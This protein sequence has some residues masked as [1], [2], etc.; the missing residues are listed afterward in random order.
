MTKS[1]A[2]KKDILTFDEIN[3][4]GGAYC[5]NDQ[6]KRAFIFCLNTG[7]RYCDVVKLTWSNINIKEARVSYVQAKTRHSSK[8]A[9]HV[10]DLNSNALQMIGKKG[11]PD[12]RVFNLPSY[13]ACLKNLKSWAKNA[14]VEKHLTWHVARHT[15]AVNLL[16]QKTDVKT[17]AGI[18]GHSGLNHINTYLRVVDELKKQAV[19]RLP[20]IKI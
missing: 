11:K 16:S 17:T 1:E 10:V 14:E 20:E 12:E 8:V 6:V 3:S 18:L 13:T 7:L 9:D 19:N 15:I 5:G 2:L 4:L